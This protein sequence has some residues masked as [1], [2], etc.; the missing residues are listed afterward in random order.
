ML[1]DSE[2]LFIYG[3]GY[4][5]NNTKVMLDDL[6]F[7]IH[8]LQTWIKNSSFSFCHLSDKVLFNER[9]IFEKSKRIF[10]KTYLSANDKVQI[11]QL[12]TNSVLYS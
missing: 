11:A 10:T 6:V 1:S 5:F 2:K 7:T 8:Y 4:N 9:N 12:E 3:N